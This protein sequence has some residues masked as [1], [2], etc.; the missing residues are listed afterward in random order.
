VVRCARFLITIII[1]QWGGQPALG[2]EIYELNL[3][4]VAPDGTA[5][6]VVFSAFGDS[7]T[8]HMNVGWG[9]ESPALF[10]SV[11]E[12]CFGFYSPQTWAQFTL[13]T[14]EGY[15]RRCPQNDAGLVRRLIVRLPS[16]SYDAS[17]QVMFQWRKRTE[18][19]LY[20]SDCVTFAANVARGAGLKVPERSLV[21][22]RNV[23]PD[24]FLGSL[25]TLNGGRKSGS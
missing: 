20:H 22:P 8:G 6:F 15:L 24:G 10:S 25:I 12:G 7:V 19:Q 9:K 1:L 21:P 11:D 13:A 18:Y 3:T 16:A 2:Q 4:E 23:F 17:L 5:Y 14:V